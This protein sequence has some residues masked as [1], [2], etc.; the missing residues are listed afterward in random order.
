MATSEAQKRASMKY[1]KNNVTQKVIRFGVNDADILEH[2]E[3]QD[4]MSGYIKRLI[5]ED[6]EKCKGSSEA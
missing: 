3:S 2:L 6:M 4:N 5:R 1:F